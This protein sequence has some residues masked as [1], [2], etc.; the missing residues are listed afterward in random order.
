VVGEFWDGVA[1]AV[2]R[3]ERSLRDTLPFAKSAKGRAPGVGAVRAKNG[4]KQVLRGAQD[5]NS[6]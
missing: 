1:A 3:R 2:G 4:R 6:N 5:D